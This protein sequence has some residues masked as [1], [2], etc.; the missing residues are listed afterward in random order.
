MK[1]NIITLFPDFFKSPL[2]TGVLG[3][4][5]HTGLISIGFTNPRD[6]A[7]DKYQSVDDSP[8]GGGDSMVMKYETLK[9]SLEFLHNKNPE[10]AKGHTVCLS[11]QGEKWDYRKAR[12]YAKKKDALT[13]ICGRYGGMDQRFINEYVTQEISVGDYVLTGGE[14]AMLVILDSLSR[15][16]KGTLGNKY[17][18]DEESFECQGL[19][20]APQWT[21]PREILGYKIP[22]VVFSGHHK[23]IK[24]FR[25]F[26]SIFITAL[27]RSDLLAL[28]SAKNDLPKAIKMVQAFSKKELKACGI[29]KEDLS[30]VKKWISKQD[31]THS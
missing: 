7:E 19:L 23:D 12:A 4:A 26:M 29:C 10:N 2:E 18:A 24:Q 13:F 5:L 21:R 17:S 6:F 3:R 22:E 11:P 20:E 30:A 31:I 14:P 1:I 28:S 16:I 9:K 15:F 8:F 27:K 25:Y